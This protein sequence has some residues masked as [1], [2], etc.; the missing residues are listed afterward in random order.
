[1]TGGSLS[2][3]SSRGVGQD[4]ININPQITF[5]RK[6][7][8]RH[9]N[10]GIESVRQ[11]LNGTIDF[12]GNLEI[13]ITKTGSLINDMHFEFTLP[14]AAG[15][16]GVDKNGDS[17]NDRIIHVNEGCVDNF[18]GYARWV[19]AVGFAIIDSIKLKFDSNT[20]DTH[21]G[22]WYDIYNELTDPNRKEW[23]LVGKFEYKDIEGTS[24]FEKSR[25]YVPIKFYFNR[26]PGLAIPI[27]LLNENELKVQLTLNTLESL[28]VFSK[29]NNND[30]DPGNP[31]I[32]SKSLSDFKFYVNYV[33]LEQEEENR[34]QGSLP[35]EYLV[36]TLDIKDNL[37]SSEATNLVF[38]NPTKEFIW[39]F[40]HPSRIDSA[41][42]ENNRIP[43]ENN[44]DLDSKNPNDIFNYSRVG[45]NSHLNYGSKDTFSK[46]TIQINNLN[47]FEQ[48]DATFFRTMQPYKYH[49]NIPGGISKNKKKQF[50]YVYSF[51]LNPEDHQPTGSY[52]F[53]IGND[54]VNFNFTGPNT[55]NEG[56]ANEIL[57]MSGYN[58]TIFST[59]YEYIVFNYGRVSISNVPF[60]SNFQEAQS[61][62]SSSVSNTTISKNAVKE[63]VKRRYAIEVPYLNNRS[64][65]KKKWSGL[66]GDFFQKQKSDDLDEKYEQKKKDIF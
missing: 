38:E 6:V 51:A 42:I 11:T 5:F 15:E 47:R 63:E 36:E 29:K 21:T 31:I 45:K 64:L 30:T 35:S 20:F 48:T 65:G 61:D 37:T 32:N 12:G 3:T 17:L 25:Y 43:A 58:L 4:V 54:L 40:R 7:Y 13:N 26:N 28:L 33:F 41:S 27:F 49:S 46:L 59:R 24:Q 66:Q 55:E 8:K 9:T 57:G 19:N 56:Q 16:N 52:N 2:L 1:M 22:L 50:I 23:P 34:I 53:S 18:K 62:S 44:P 14:P 10:F 60:Q 39:V